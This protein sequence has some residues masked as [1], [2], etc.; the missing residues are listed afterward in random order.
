VQERVLDQVACQPVEVVGHA[1]HRDRTGQV[2]R[3]R[4]V[5]GERSRLGGRLA[6]DRA[7]V[8]RDG[9]HL[10]AGVGPGQQQQVG[11]QPAHP[12]RRAQRGLGHLAPLAV[13][14]GLEQLEVRQDAGERRAELV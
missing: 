1:A 14:L 11:H 7:E 9:G 4:V 2:E 8:D 5:R 10:A 3:K 12:A 6:R 13:Q